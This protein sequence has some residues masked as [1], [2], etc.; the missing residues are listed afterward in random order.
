MYVCFLRFHALAIQPIIMQYCI[1][2]VRG[3][4]N[5]IRFLLLSAKT[6]KITIDCFYKIT[7]HDWKCQ[8]TTIIIIYVNCSFVTI[9][10][11]VIR[12]FIG[13][14]LRLSL[15]LGTPRDK[16]KYTCKL[17]VLVRIF[18]GS[19]ILNNNCLRCIHLRST[20]R[21]EARVRTYHMRHRTS[22]N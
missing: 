9:I 17:W 1:H 14:L 19:D 2:D 6:S 20:L 16:H 15:L 8:L 12:F 5:D 7:C 21:V 4:E 22:D 13:N 18:M 3:I 10:I 11:F